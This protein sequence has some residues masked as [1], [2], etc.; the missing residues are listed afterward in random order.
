MMSTDLLVRLDGE[1][2]SQ[3]PELL[4]KGLWR[5]SSTSRSVH[6]VFGESMAFIDCSVETLVVVELAGGMFAEYSIE[7]ESRQKSAQVEL[8]HLVGALARSTS[9]IQ[10]GF[11][12]RW[13]IGVR[14][15]I[16]VDGETADVFRSTALLR[17]PWIRL[18]RV[19]T[20]GVDHAC[21]LAPASSAQ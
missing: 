2:S 20:F 4:R 17:L 12:G 19:G 9:V 15:S 14:I 8:I 5:S 18:S 1:V 11:V 16:V 10:R 6:N 21:P 3:F 7:R 13:T